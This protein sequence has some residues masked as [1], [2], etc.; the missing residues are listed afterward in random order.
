MEVVIEIEE[1][2]GVVKEMMVEVDFEIDMEV[3]G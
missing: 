2:A 1:E 3:K